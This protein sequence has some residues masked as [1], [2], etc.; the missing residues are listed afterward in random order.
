MGEPKNNV[1]INFRVA[2]GVGGL[3]SS[4]GTTSDAG[5][6]STTV[7]LTNH[8]SDVQVTACVAPNNIAKPL[9]CSRP[10][11]SRWTLESV[12]GSVQVIPV[13]QP[14]QPLVLRITD[15]ASPSNP[16]MGVNLIF[17]VT[18]AR[19]PKDNGGPPGGG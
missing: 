14:F 5:Y 17:D 1:S 16:V 19:I 9:L 8:S 7:Q 3:T 2:K 15:G 10:P 18:L 13:G 12:G 11:A 4:T 6:G